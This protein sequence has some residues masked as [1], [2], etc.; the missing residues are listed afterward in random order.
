MSV[1][2]AA[3]A[4]YALVTARTIRLAPQSQPVWSVLRIP[5]DVDPGADQRFD[6]LRIRDDRGHD[7]PYVLDPQCASATSRPGTL[8]GT[9]W[10]PGHYT[11]TLIDTG[12]S[13]DLYDAIAIDT[14]KST[15]FTRA[16]VA[17][18]DDRQTWRILRSDALIYRVAASSDPG[19][20]TIA[21]TPSRA[22]WIRL[23]LLDARE[24]FPLNG[25]DV[26]N[27]APAAG[28]GDVPLGVRSA[29]TQKTLK[30]TILTLDLGTQ[31]TQVGSL[32]F[33]TA[34]AEFSRT[35]QVEGSSDGRWWDDLASGTIERFAHG[36]S[37]LN[38]AVESSSNR[39]LRVRVE[40]G[41]DA[42]LRSLRVRAYG[43]ARTVVFVAQ[44][45]RRY[46]LLV[47]HGKSAPDYDLPQILAH[48]NPRRLVA[49][50]AIGK[51]AF[52][53]AKAAAPRREPPA[54]LFT[55]AFAAAIAVMGAV[56]V[57]A[58]KRY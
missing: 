49:A 17:I 27:A 24:P 46:T 34:Q 11:E 22:R 19:S 26:S 13:G 4:S 41:D 45:A 33:S 47:L 38:L 35:V 8:S 10:V 2:T 6:G 52:P 40:N 53:R 20:Q 16:E 42:P 14:P 43:P 29:K 21:L 30:E 15:F 32:R 5:Q 28:P 31:H 50:E 48:D 18:S 12:A 37:S 44:P 55:I 9:G 51:A 23:R 36:S 3:A 56:T 58:L 7:V 25:I 39:Y 1:A 57:R 54:Y